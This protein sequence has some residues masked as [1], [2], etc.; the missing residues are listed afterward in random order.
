MVGAA[1]GRMV[2]AV[3]EAATSFGF[4]MLGMPPGSDGSAPPPRQV[5]LTADEV[6]WLAE[7]EDRDRS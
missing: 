5:R 7:L 3:W 2:G 6:L 4:A 1:A